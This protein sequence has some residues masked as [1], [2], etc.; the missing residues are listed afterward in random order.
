[1]GLAVS[2]YGSHDLTGAAGADRRVWR[3]L[4]DPR[5]AAFVS[6]RGRPR[7]V[8]QEGGVMDFA[9]FGWATEAV[10]INDLLPDGNEECQSEWAPLPGNNVCMDGAGRWR[11]EHSWD[12][13]GMCIFCPAH[14]G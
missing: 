7:D 14:L 13:D 3:E 11:R 8:R 6:L 1:M 9:E 4:L 5:R 12:K 2:V 10:G